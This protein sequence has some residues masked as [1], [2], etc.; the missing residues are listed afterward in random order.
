MANIYGPILPLQLDPRNTSALVRDMQTK[1]FL[2][3]DGQLND[4]SP[5]SPLSALVE[6]QAF[7]QAELLYYLNS[8][9]EAYT[10]QWLRQLGLQREV[11]AK[12]T[13]EVTF[14]K[15]R[16]FGRSLIIPRGTIVSTSNRLNFVLQQE[17]RIE[18]EESSA[19]GRALAEKWGSVY[20][21]SANDIEKINVNILGLERS[22]N[23]TP[24]EGGKDLE[25]IESLKGRAFSLLRRRSLISPEDY[26]LEVNSVAPEAAIVKVLTYEDRFN[27]DEEMLSGNVMICVS[28]EDGNKLSN[29]VIS[30]IGKSIKKRM[31]MGNT[32]S[33]ISPS[34]SPVETS[35]SI[36]Y[37]DEVYTD[38]INSFAF[39]I[40][41]ILKSLINP[42]EIELGDNIDYQKV[43]NSIYNLEFVDN[44]RNLSF[45]VLQLGVAGTDQL[46]YCNSPFVSELIDGV[47]IDTPEAVI[48]DINLAYNNSNPIKSYRG[49]KNIISFI[50]KSSQAPLTF[51]FTDSDYDSILRS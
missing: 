45:K 2:E 24:A 11:G 29:S 1:I 28:D 20:N 12:A 37:D 41:A 51:T 48:D 44:V 49:Y 6:G 33:I 47:C 3:S 10:L 30:N 42:S 4:F 9:P 35:V 7:A 36:L 8:L 43:F 40:D 27:L 21:V 46:N 23:F 26:E 32:V 17:V 16:G 22:T 39:E 5:A 25:S 15:S 18:N 13:V 38:G 31:P 50:A 14:I 34:I 19:V